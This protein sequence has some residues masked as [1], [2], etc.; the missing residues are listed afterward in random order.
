MTTSTTTA[1]RVLQSMPIAHTV[2]N[3]LWYRGDTHLG[4][5]ATLKQTIAPNDRLSFRD[6]ASL[7][8]GKQ[9]V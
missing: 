3:H 2:L 9:T 7:A 8:A 6:V 1:S 4:Y 5:V